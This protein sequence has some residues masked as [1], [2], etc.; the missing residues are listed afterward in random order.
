MYE[1]DGREGLYQ[2]ATTLLSKYERR[3]SVDNLEKLCYAQFCKEYDPYRKSKKKQ[4]TE[5]SDRS[6]SEELDEEM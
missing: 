2:E 3:G 4:S 1:I 6:E 5:H